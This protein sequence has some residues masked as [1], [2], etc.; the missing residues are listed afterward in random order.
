MTE[1]STI[2]Q[3]LAG[4]TERHKK[5]VEKLLDTVKDDLHY[6]ELGPIETEIENKQD[7]VKVTLTQILHRKRSKL[8]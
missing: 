2:H 7:E 4:A 5:K 8:S 1:M 3:T 6:Y